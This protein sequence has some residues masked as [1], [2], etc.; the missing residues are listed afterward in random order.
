MDSNFGSESLTLK[1]WTLTLD[2][3]FVSL[4]EGIF[5]SFAS[6]VQRVMV[7]ML[8]SFISSHFFLSPIFQVQVARTTS[9]IV[10][11]TR[12]VL[13]VTALTVKTPSLAR[14]I[15]VCT[16][17]IYCTLC[18]IQ[19]HKVQENYKQMENYCLRQ[20]IPS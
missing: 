13:M 14:A 10:H 18:G 8:H 9:T 17:F 12:A 15:Q 7:T 2:Q 6:K 19:F 3:K 4:S 5:L 1:L 16:F 11:R 20:S